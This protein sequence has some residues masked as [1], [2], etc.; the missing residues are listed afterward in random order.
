M[1]RKTVALM[2]ALTLAVSLT[3]CG[4]GSVP[5][6]TETSNNS[7]ITQIKE[8]EQRIEELEA[9]N[10]ELRAQLENSDSTD[11]NQQSEA[12]SLLQATIQSPETSGVCGA[13]LT[14]YYQNG[15][16]AIAGT[17]EMA[18]YRRG[19]NEGD[20]NYKITTPWYDIKDKIGWVIIDDGVTS[21]GDYAFCKCFTLSKIELP[22][23]LTT[24]GYSAFYKCENIKEINLPNSIINIGG[25]AFDDDI[26]DSKNMTIVYNGQTYT[27]EEYA[28]LA[29]EL[30]IGDSGMFG[31]YTEEPAVE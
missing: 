2:T 7:D 8:L 30:N 18:D 3:A 25:K 11:N 4:N 29:N 14:W 19:E 5:H 16:L 1:K 31:W 21:I 10:K 26:E 13:N 27:E 20:W 6:E 9:E 15:V 24:I 23:T 12:D 22:K 28:N 17:G